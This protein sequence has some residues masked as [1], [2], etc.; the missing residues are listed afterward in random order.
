MKKLRAKR[1][2]RQVKCREGVVETQEVAKI[3]STYI[4]N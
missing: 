3:T 1:R 4:V 2:E